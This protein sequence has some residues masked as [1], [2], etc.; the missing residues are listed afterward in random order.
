[1]NVERREASVSKVAIIGAGAMGLAAAYYALKA[2][3]DVVVYEADKVPGGMAAHFDFG[4]LSIERF[5]HFVCKA[6]QATFELMNDLGIA[7]KMNW[8][9]TSMG[10]YVD[11]RLY[12]WGDPIALL[13]FAKL[14]PIEKLRYSLMMFFAVRRRSSG[15]LESL[16][17][18]TWIERWCGKRVYALLWEPLFTLKF[19]D[20]AN[21]ISAAWIWTRIKRVGSSRRSLMQEELGYIE[22]GTQT[23]IEA[24][25]DAIR[26]MGGQ[27]RLGT[28][29]EEVV[30]ADAAVTGLAMGGEFE[31][32]DWVISTIPTPLVPR[33]V[34][35]LPESSKAAYESIKNIGVVCLVFKLK[36]S[37]TP[38]FWVNI[39]DKTIEIPGIVE[40]SN[41]RPTGHTIVF[42]PLYMPTTFHKWSYSDQRIIAEAFSY[43]QR[44]NTKLSSDD[45]IECKVARLRYAQ[46]VCPVGF[47]AKIPPVQTP[48]A[49]LMIADTCFYYPED[50]GISESVHFGRMMARALDESPSSNEVKGKSS[51]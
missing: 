13:R 39:S 18:K 41:L 30:V 42:V 34:P 38:Y 43:L 47:A 48:I 20:L 21:D 9:A 37:V 14:S 7:D 49:R 19:H 29:V 26:R 11:G 8:V 32:F 25:A 23:L 15:T 50:R 33:L 10:Y 1:M 6:D 35:A 24:L 5:Y 22:G 46:P 2:G 4:G 51:I 31:A 27:I 17:A 16:S 3:H 36:I 40:F 28:K 44:L 12:K 45:V